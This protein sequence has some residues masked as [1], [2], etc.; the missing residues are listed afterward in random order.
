LNRFRRQ[1]RNLQTEIDAAIQRVLDSGWFLLGEE[2]KRFEGSFA[3]FL[4]VKYAV[5][6]ASGTDAITL[7]LKASGLSPGDEVITTS[8]TAVGTIVGIEQAGGKPVFVD[9]DPDSFTIDVN[10]IESVVTEHTRAIVPV[11]L[12]GHPANMTSVMELA[13]LYDLIVVEDCAQAHG[14]EWQAQFVGTFGHAGAFSFYPTKMLGAYGDAGMVI[15]NDATTYDTI[16]LLREYG[17]I[18]R[19][20]I[21]RGV[22]SRLDEMQAAIL[23]VKLPYLLAWI[24]RHREIAELYSSGLLSS[25]LRLPLE[26]WNAQHVYHQYVVRTPIRETLYKFLKHEGVPVAIHYRTPVHLMRAY[27]DLGYPF[28]SLPET[29]KAAGEVLSLPIFPEMTNEEIHEIIDKID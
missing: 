10:K 15:T 7:A 13:A 23:N 22:N 19:A 21:I 6:V 20:S 29:E 27:N 18:D 9:I 25:L 14:A 17:W 11:H 28:G 24:G 16:R 4:G 8:F 12:Y 26:K 2:L 5:G 1:Y 3:N